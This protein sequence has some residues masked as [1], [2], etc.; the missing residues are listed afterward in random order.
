MGTLD[1]V[2]LVFILLM[3]LSGAIFGLLG[4]LSKLAAFFCA[5]ILAYFISSPINGALVNAGAYDGIAEKMDG[6]TSLANS[7]MFIVVCFLCFLL[8]YFVFWLLFH[9]FTKAI[10]KF[11]VFN[12]IDHICGFVVGFFMAVILCGLT[13]LVLN[14]VASDNMDLYVWLQEDVAKSV[15]ITKYINQYVLT[16]IE[17]SM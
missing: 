2:F 12:I 14:M 11:K 6:N 3:T 17:S 4:K 15:F 10:K 7:V 9:R 13:M 16:A 5:L 8:F 1:I